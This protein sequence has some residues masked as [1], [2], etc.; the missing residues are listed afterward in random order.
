MLQ[1][2]VLDRCEFCDGQA[3]VY[4]C[5]FVDNNGET[6]PRYMPCAY[7]KG[8]GEL[9]KWVRLTDLVE[10]LEQLLLQIYTR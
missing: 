6:Y 1:V 3:Y 7:C 10:L 5:E 8:S 9:N 2:H 4:A